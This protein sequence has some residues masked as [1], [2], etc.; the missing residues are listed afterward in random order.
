MF[1]TLVLEESAMKTLGVQAL[2]KAI[3]QTMAQLKQQSDEFAQVKKM[4][5][6]LHHLVML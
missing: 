6:A 5:R 3:D 1:A 2:H 4:L